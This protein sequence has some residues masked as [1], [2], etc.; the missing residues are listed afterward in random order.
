MEVGFDGGG[1]VGC[2]IAGEIPSVGRNRW[3]ETL[4]VAFS[5]EW[6]GIGL[7]VVGWVDVESKP[8]PFKKRVRHPKAILRME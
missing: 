4:A 6:R 2:E 5:F 7:S 1:E 8:A 3:L